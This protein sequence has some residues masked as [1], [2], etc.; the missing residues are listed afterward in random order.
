MQPQ[1][2]L[3]DDQEQLKLPLHLLEYHPSFIS[4]EK[5][6]RLLYKLISGTPW[7][8]RKQ[9]L[10]EKEVITPR[11]TAFYGD[12]PLREADSREVLPWTR[13]LLDLKYEV[14]EHT[15]IIFEGVLLNYYRDGQDSVAWHSDKDTVPGM[16]T[17]IASVSLGQVRKF[18]YRSKLDHRK[19]YS[20]DLGHGSLLMKGDLQR[21][22]E[23]RIAKSTIPMKA[24]INLTFRKLTV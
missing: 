7:Q 5:G 22:R 18:D 9:Q 21:Y 3:F 8:Q 14:E 19:K 10:Y 13:E 23:H 20:I 4:A 11:L 17:E 12:A 2:S 15:G 16:K 24:R 1:L 6:S